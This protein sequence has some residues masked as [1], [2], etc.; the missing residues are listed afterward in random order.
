M[1]TRQ[2]LSDSEVAQE[3][4]QV[5]GHLKGGYPLESNCRQF[6]ARNCRDNFL[7]RFHV[8]VK[9]VDSHYRQVSDR[10]LSAALESF[11]AVAYPFESKNDIG[12]YIFKPQSHRI[13]R[14]L[15]RTIGCDLANVRPI[16]NVCFDLQ[17]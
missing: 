15:D 4:S 8:R 5:D 11:L 2:K 13:V 3:N 16:D 6:G 17:I 12:P 7:M 9:Y 1:S 14:L 10:K